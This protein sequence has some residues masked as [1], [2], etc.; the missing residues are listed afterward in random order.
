[1]KIRQLTP[2]LKR[3]KKTRKKLKSAGRHR[4]AA[5]GAALARSAPKL[6]VTAWA[7]EPL[8]FSLFK[9]ETEI[10]TERLFTLLSEE[11]EKLT[12]ADFIA[13]P[14]LIR[15]ALFFRAAD[16]PDDER[17]FYA[18]A[19][20]D[21]ERLGEE[22]N[23]LSRL[24]RE[25]DTYRRS[26][27]ETKRL[28]RYKTSRAAAETGIDEARLAREYMATAARSGSDLCSVVWADARRIF[29]YTTPIAYL[30]AQGA[31][32]I[33][34][35]ALAV[36]FSDLWVGLSVFAPA[37]AIAKTIADRFLLKSAVGEPLP[38][39]TAD[40]AEK[41]AAVCVLSALTDSPAALREAVERLDL[42]RIKNPAP[43]LLF[44]L[45]CDLPPARTRETEADEAILAEAARLAAEPDAPILLV[46]PRDYSKTQDKYQ[47][48][49]RKRGAIEDLVRFIAGESV[50]FRFTAGDLSRL[51]GIPFLVA[52]DYDTVPLMD[53][54]NALVAA[55]LHPVNEPYGIIAPRITTSL[56]SAMRTGFSRLFSGSGGCSGASAYDSF[57]TELYSARFGEGT[58]TGKGLLR[59]ERF[60]RLCAGKLPEERVLS[61]DILEGG[62]LGVAYDGGIE[63]SDSFPPT[64]KGYFKRLHRW[65]RGDFQNIRFLA[66]RRLSLL[67]R[68]KLSDN[69]RRGLAP[70]Y[71]MFSLF[72][73]AIGGYAVPAAIVL[74]SI[75]LPYLLGLIPAA[76]RGLGFS[77]TREF[78]APVFS[79]SRQ[80]VSRLFWEVIFLPKNAVLAL[81]AAARTILRLMTGKKL[82]EWQTASQFD[83]LGTIGYGGMLLPELAALVLLY[84]SLITGN[85]PTAI[86]AGLMSFAL[87]AAI[88][89]DKPLAGGAP[90]I[91]ARERADLS[92]QAEKLW[93]FY[94]DY[95]TE[96]EHFLPPDNVQYAPV[97]RVARRTS[98]TN[99]GMYLISCISAA[100]LGLI[101]E[102]AAE[103]YLAR[104]IATVERLEK[105]GGNLYNWYS[106]EDLSTLSPFVSSVDS[107]NLLCCL[108]AVRSWLIKK[109][110]S[111]LLP[112]KIKAL[113]DGADLTIFYNR[114]RR[115]FSVGIDARTGKQAPNCYDLLMSE[116]RMLSY[117]AIA[118]GQA[119]KEHWRALSRL[120]S[121]NGSYAGPVAWTGTMFE[122]FMPELLLESKAGSLSYEALSYAVYCQRERGKSR[123]L[124]FGVSESGYFSFDRELNYQYKAHGVQKLALCSGMDRE[125]V[126]SP[127]ST[128][129]ALSHSFSACMENLRRL[130]QP[131]FM[132][133]RY[134]CYEA[135][136]LTDTRTGGADAVVKSHMAHHV[137]MSLGGIANALNDGVLRK[138][139][140][141]D[142]TMRRADEL[143]EERIMSGE[144]IVDLE[145]FREKRTLG[146]EAEEFNDL[147]ILR[148]RMSIA[149]NRKLAVFMTDTGLY[150]GRFRGSATMIPSPDFLRRPRGMFFGVSAGGREIPFYLSAYD[151]GESAERSVV[152]SENGAEYYVNA[153]GLRLGMR[154]SLFGE[155]AAELREFSI[156]NL[157]NAERKVDL[158]AFF[159]PALAPERDINAHPAFMDL[160]LTP[161][162]DEGENLVLVRRK[163]RDGDGELWLCIG[164][165]ETADY[166]YSFDREKVLRP[167]E[168]LSFL[169]SAGLAE[170]DPCSIPSPCILLDLPVKLDAGGSYHTELF[171]CYGKSRGEVLGIAHDARTK[172]EKP[173]VSPLPGATLQGRIARKLLPSLLCRSVYPEEVLTTPAPLGRRALWRF[174]IGGD[175]P[176]LLYRYD[177]VE[178]NLESAILTVGGLSDC[179]VET[180]LVILCD[181]V[182]RRER[183][184]AMIPDLRRNVFVIDRGAVSAEEVA[185]LTRSAV[186]LFGKSELKKAPR[187]LMEIVPADP[188]R[189]KRRE[190]FIDGGY[191]VTKKG[192]PMT[193]V[194]ASRAFGCVL[195]QNSLGFSYALNSRENKLTPWYNDPLH[196]NDGELI[197]L[198]G[199]GVYH[200]LVAGAEAVFSPNKADYYGAVGRREYSVSVRVFEK[201]MGKEITVRLKNDSAAEKPYALSYYLEPILGADIFSSDCGAA[202]SFRSDDRAVYVKN[203]AN[204]D[205][206][207]EM[208]VWCDHETLKTTNRELFLSGE[209]AGE[210]RPYAHGCIALTARGKLPPRGSE[211]IRF[212]LAFSR[213]DG[214][215]QL[216][217]FSKVGTDWKSARLPQIESRSP[218]LNA[219]FK[220]W[221]PWQVV[222]CRLWSRSAF[223][224]NGGAFGFRDQLQ[225]SLAAIEFMPD[226]TKRQILRCCASQF[227]EGD[228]LHWWHRT[229]RGRKGVRTLCSD[230]LLWLPYVTAV[231]VKKT[232]DREILSLPVQYINGEPLGERHEKYMEVENSDVRESVYRHCKKALEK[233]FKKGGHALLKM[234]GG[235]WND[236]YNRVGVRGRGESVW[237]SMFYVLVVKEFAP[238]ARAEGDAAYADELEKR[239]A[240][241]TQSIEGEAFENGYYLR[242]FYD[243][244]RK[245]GAAE[246]E[247]CRID[248]LPQAFAVLADLP[249]REKRDSALKSAYQYLVD[250]QDR[251]IRLFTPA[252]DRDGEE[253]P[254]YV[255]SYPVGVRENGGQ[256]THAAVWLALA[257]LKSGDKVTAR[258][259]ADFL[260]PAKRGET[261]KNEP[262]YMTADIYTNPAALGRGGWSVYT[263]AAAWYYLLLKELYSEE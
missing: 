27:R 127:Y 5:E 148:P 170:N 191:V 204:S 85:I 21:V 201:G 56:S 231:Y 248:L 75:T 159:E 109:R 167:N 105:Y 82:L 130:C 222:G 164:F 43:N 199:S 200:D 250:E 87:P 72:L 26:S 258:R 225:D 241:L 195:S 129:L 36:I 133:E 101:G 92:E 232:E 253:D 169:K 184:V 227:P 174:G 141:S 156:E 260:N 223:Y 142:E 29:P 172:E 50:A 73:A 117:Y 28:C 221:L 261:F 220:T 99:I 124:P 77:N 62:L 122:F 149:A 118:S 190:G 100:E 151:S 94:E 188:P 128:F 134:G 205:F 103:T 67:T 30:A 214:R 61:H 154:L 140:L 208:A 81:D 255:K 139:F 257:F 89:L 202:L 178:M 80:L 171:I 150:Y 212:I 111:P 7:G 65:L 116:S 79:L 165:K 203:E 180:D 213:G 98:P 252:F 162:Y 33:A 74:L 161:E 93:R 8:I 243:D 110:R 182:A 39:V 216:Q 158:I 19:D 97:Y 177:G 259:L 123:R 209:A 246:N 262:Y 37:L 90:R 2:I 173:A 4:L 179:G 152:F 193:H 22:L 132:H 18:A 58:F 235:D 59:T 106:T 83:S 10:T 251:L 136:D 196:D 115:L 38:A 137:G 47:G 155:N 160:F 71:A 163:E 34:V 16:D 189:E 217:A 147:S 242:A 17:L 239:A 6:P 135:I 210:L 263:G 108:V 107:G 245:M 244:G 42:A 120:M 35:T 238:I 20:V 15:A 102:E 176:I 52:L 114:V 145:R 121:R 53:S 236:G 78:Y 146:R 41:S 31:V 76:L 198:R 234:G 11:A 228:V 230:D 187:R 13:L 126:I 46:R 112:Q 86:A 84:L 113:L 194:L 229:D 60:Y 186:F 185:L 45:L 206:S 131:E 183:I 40:E 57:D 88:L 104:T 70:L 49:E 240:E 69:I 249:D 48:K 64:S 119:E 218:E 44:C 197:L 175:R 14:W 32:A 233:S 24:Y 219:L 226:E 3:L 12:N 157:T 215:K 211:T 91:G 153:A 166:R 96:E 143:L 256:Y 95:V 54:V 23:P 68:F 144:V 181:G 9:D 207:G 254:G 247:A 55:A 66:D 168:P 1:M 192:K 224:Q 237:L 25:D 138:L 51:R 63:F 125:Y